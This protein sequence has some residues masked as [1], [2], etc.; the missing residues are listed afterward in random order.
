MRKLSIVA[1]VVILAS[2]LSVAGYA[3]GDNSDPV[4]VSA[5]INDSISLKVVDGQSVNFGTNLNPNNA[6]FEM[7][8]TTLEVS[9]TRNGWEVSHDVTGPSNVL[10][11]RYGSVNN[12]QNFGRLSSTSRG[13]QGTHEVNVNYKLDNLE[14]LGQNNVNLTVQF[15]VTA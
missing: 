15:T 10:S 9:S 6:H 12:T 11:I 7:S 14:T 5:H 13:N 1:L 4:S 2:A 8:A 3:I